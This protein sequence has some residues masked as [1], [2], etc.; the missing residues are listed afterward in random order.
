M[1]QNFKSI[2]KI[3][4]LL[5]FYSSHSPYDYND[6]IKQIPAVPQVGV[7]VEEQAIGYYL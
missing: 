1:T 4:T 3:S 2:S 5:H 7:G 6:E